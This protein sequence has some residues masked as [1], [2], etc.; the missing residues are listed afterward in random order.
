MNVYKFYLF[1]YK[2]KEKY[3]ATTYEVKHDELQ[4]I[5]MYWL[6]SIKPYKCK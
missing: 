4:N 2:D 3:L 1:L 6:L 5:L